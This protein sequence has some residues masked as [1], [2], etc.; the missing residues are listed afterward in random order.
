[1]GRMTLLYEGPGLLSLVGLA[2]LV[3]SSVGWE[4]PDSSMDLNGENEG[5]FKATCGKR[6][7]PNLEVRFVNLFSETPSALAF[8]VSISST[9]E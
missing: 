1:M 8:L 4:L 5:T 3:Q 6:S 7:T 2:G 9:M